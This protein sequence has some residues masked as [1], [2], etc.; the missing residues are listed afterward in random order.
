[1][2]NAASDKTYRAY[3]APARLILVPPPMRMAWGEEDIFSATSHAWEI[4]WEER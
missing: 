2:R 3:G 1:M 4:L